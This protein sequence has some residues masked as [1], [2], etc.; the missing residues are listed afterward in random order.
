MRTPSLALSCLSTLIV[1]AEPQLEVAGSF[2]LE[3]VEG[4]EIIS[5]HA[6]SRRAVVTC[7]DVGALLVLDLSTPTQPKQLQLIKLGLLANEEVT[8]AALHPDG[9]RVLVAIKAGVDQKGRV[10]VWSLS[11]ATRLAAAEAGYCCDSVVIAPD[12]MT[13]LVCDEA[14][15]ISVV[16]GQAM[17]PPGSVTLI[18]LGAIDAPVTA[19]TI[20]LSD[21]TGTPGFTTADAGRFLERP[22]EAGAANFRGT[23]ATKKEGMFMLPLVDA[24]PDVLEPEGAVFTPDGTTAWVTLQE[25]NG[26]L[27]IDIA[28]AKVTGAFGLGETE[29]MADITD[30]GKPIFSH[31]LTALREP[32]GIA[33]TP[34]GRYLVTGDEGDTDPKASKIKEGKPAGGGRTVSVIDAAT[35]KVLGDTRNGIDEAAAAAGCY[36]DKRSPNKGSEP[37][38][39]ATFAL[40]GINYAVATLERADAV[41][42]ISLADPA[43]PRVLGVTPLGKGH[44]APE[45][46]A[47][48]TFDDV[49]HVF[50]ANEKSGT[51]TIL[52]LRP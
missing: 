46:L 27:R 36:P 6:A 24:A 14:E 11:S 12:G 33:I 18:R 13:A 52:T 43:Q 10:E 51:I 3:G 28:A 32:D 40:G 4:C 9:E 39:V 35:G 19:T 31:E 45:G 47:V 16:G 21:L 25:N 29:H 30:D 15:D 48:V 44:K 17:S 23:A 7:S 50:T 37:E 8:S 41:A 38:M 49:I 22:A 1:A 34:D 20:A 42:F 26:L 2:T 5:V